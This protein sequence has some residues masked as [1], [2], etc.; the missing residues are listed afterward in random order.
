MK[1]EWTDITT[2]PFHNTQ[3][4]IVGCQ[5]L[6]YQH[7]SAPIRVYTDAS[8]YGIGAY[9]CQVAEEVQEQPI[10]FLSKTLSKAEK[11][12]S[13]YEKE[14]YAIF[15]A[16]RKW[17]HL[18]Q[19][20]K[21]T[22]YTDHKNLTYLNT[23]PSPKV[24][25]WKI[26]VQEYDFDI[27]YVPGEE[28][29]VADGFSRLCPESLITE[30]E[31]N[32][33][34]AMF[35]ESYPA[36]QR[37]ID[38][39]EFLEIQYHE[40]TSFKVDPIYIV[41]AKQYLTDRVSE[42]N[43]LRSKN[44]KPTSRKRSEQTQLHALNVKRFK[45]H[46]I[47]S[48]LYEIIAKC[49]NSKEGHGGVERTIEKVQLYLGKNKQLHPDLV[50]HTMRRDV[51]SFIYMCPCCQLN[52]IQKFQIDTK[53]YTTSKYG[54]F[55]NLSIDAIYVPQSDAGFKYILVIID[56]GSRYVKT[57][58]L[59][60]LT[61]TTA[62]EV[63]MTYMHMFGIPSEICTDNSTQ[64]ESV[65]AEMLDLLQAHAYKIH[66]YSHQENSIVERANREV[67]RHLR[68]IIFDE[69][70]MR[71]WPEYLP[72]VE[73]IINSQ[74]SRATGV[75][76]VEMVFA[77][78]VDINQGR[79]YPQTGNPNRQEPVSEHMQAIIQKQ[80]TLWE[81]AHKTQTA[82]DM[83]HLS[84]QGGQSKTEFAIDSMVTVAYENDEHKPPTKLHNRRRGPFRVVSKTTREE[85]DVYNC[86]DLITHRE[87][88]F[89]VTLLAPFVY[90][91]I[92][93][94]LTDVEATEKQMYMVEK[95]IG[96]RWKNPQA[97]KV[98]KLQR[99]DNLEIEIK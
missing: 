25:R 2:K 22:L 50:W 6:Y 48:Q 57:Y 16:L 9:I 94:N 95:V 72:Q 56:S 30:E 32:I 31:P 24:Q 76:P 8:H 90:D 12:W 49:H 17:E 28:N 15:Y 83:F 73:H 54:V 1:L 38:R 89:H 88:S 21:F 91:V 80:N 18:L 11:K 41:E 13:V 97:E 63:V 52:E 61:A 86:V 55:N 35:L 33:S 96:H 44:L 93:T 74:T 45:P 3:Q 68:N 79:L 75:S 71:A 87:E 7:P 34:I 82:T 10:A 59:R 65:F 92:R 40:P 46:H 47:P 64:F 42:I 14:A 81:I 37:R 5:L 70:I 51:Q 26:A 60:N 36:V 98:R 69:K 39:Q 67:L 66:P 77:G 27:A 85:G 29:I 53:K 84:R 43:Y 58:P 62:A 23:D 4:A 78:Q 99:P 20:V 19:D